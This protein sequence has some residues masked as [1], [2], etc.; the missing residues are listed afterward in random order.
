MR[1]PAHN[2]LKLHGQYTTSAPQRFE[3]LTSNTGAMATYVLRG[4]MQNHKLNILLASEYPASPSMGTR[5]PAREN[6]QQ[7]LVDQTMCLFVTRAQR[8]GDV[9]L[10]LLLKLFLGSCAYVPTPQAVAPSLKHHHQTR[11]AVITTESASCAGAWA[12]HGDVQVRVS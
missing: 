4:S 11:H 2:H 5:E 9:C 7:F 12:R 6:T 3:G 8:L 1:R 10:V